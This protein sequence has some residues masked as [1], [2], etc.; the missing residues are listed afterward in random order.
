MG[1]KASIIVINKPS[2]VDSKKLLQEL[3]FT[4]LIKVE[5]E[6]FEVCFCN[7]QKVF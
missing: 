3:G 7:L 5:D 1:W 4:N 2:Q 6:P